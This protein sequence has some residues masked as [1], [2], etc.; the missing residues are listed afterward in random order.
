MIGPLHAEVRGSLA[1]GPTVVFLPGLGGTTRYWSS[2]VAALE[3]RYRV[4]LVDLLGFGDSPRPWARYSVERHVQSLAEVLRPYGRVTLVG[5]SLGALLAIAYAAREPERVGG[6][7]LLGMPC[8]TG[9]RDA[10]EHY[11]HG[12]MRAGFLA[13]NV[14]LA[15]ATC[16]MTR[17]LLGRLLPYLLR[18]V[19]RE[20]AEDLVKHN[21][22]SATSSLWEV[23]Y[24]YDALAD[25]ESLPR[26]I[27][28]LFIH[29]GRDVMAPLAAVERAAAG[30]P[31]WRLNVFPDSDH[32]PFLRDPRAC[33]RLIDGLVSGRAV[34]AL[35]TEPTARL[36]EGAG[37]DSP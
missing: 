26:R 37:S 3:R 10:Y 6:L 2:R 36:T 28:V 33:L 5:H 13:T 4:V 1:D 34:A 8:F 21:W 23:V 15:A 20:V 14:V 12:P 11:R 25:L 27:D 19:P 17:R 22:R 24:R 29:G 18:H 16:I 30:H 9:Q 7:A 35:G 32:H 31:W